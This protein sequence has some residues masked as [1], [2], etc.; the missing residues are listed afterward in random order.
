MRPAL[1]SFRTPLDRETLT[2]DPAVDYHL[3]LLRVSLL[4]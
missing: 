4:K 2:Q 3:A 1:N